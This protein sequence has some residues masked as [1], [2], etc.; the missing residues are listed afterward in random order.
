MNTVGFTEHFWG[1]LILLIILLAMA[2]AAF[3]IK[4]EKKVFLKNIRKYILQGFKVGT[5]SW[6]S[7]MESSENELVFKRTDTNYDW[8]AKFLITK[9]DDLP[10]EELLVKKIKEKKVLFD[11]DTSEIPGQ[12]RIEREFILGSNV[13]F[14]IARVEG[15]AT[16]DEYDRLY[17]DLAIFRDKKRDLVL[18]CESKSSILNGAVEGPYFE[19]VIKRISI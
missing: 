2:Y 6:W 10:I 4:N 12:D 17:L 19:E 13:D 9:N 11:E 15:T 7:L 8:V 1:W 18:L 16:T 5:P 14:E 3:T